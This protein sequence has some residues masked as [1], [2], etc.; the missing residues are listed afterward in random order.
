MNAAENRPGRWRCGA[1][2]STAE[3]PDIP[4][5]VEGVIALPAA[6]RAS[7]GGCGAR[8][9]ACTWTVLARW[10]GPDAADGVGP[11]DGVG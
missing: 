3:G 1:A 10:A 2:D 5:A 9:T 11:G 6:I 8:D 4:I 7:S